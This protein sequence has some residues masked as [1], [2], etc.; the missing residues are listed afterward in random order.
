MA[1]KFI[2]PFLARKN[3]KN[4]KILKKS[5]NQ[6]FLAR[7][8]YEFLPTSTS[9]TGTETSLRR[10]N[11]KRTLGRRLYREQQQQQQHEGSTNPV[12]DKGQVLT[13][14]YGSR[15]AYTH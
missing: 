6:H 5:K 11:K 13:T 14:T 9:M 7:W 4:A 12:K 2:R 1:M 10:H 15:H 3:S 8:S